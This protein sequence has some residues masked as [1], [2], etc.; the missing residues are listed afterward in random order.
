MRIANRFAAGAAVIASIVLCSAMAYAE[1]KIG[2]LIYSGEAHYVEAARGA[3]DK[4]KEEG[5]GEP[6]ATFIVENAGANKAKA[7]DLAQKLAAAKLDLII[8]LGTSATIAAMREIRDVP[9]V[10]ALV[11]DPVEAGIAKTWESSGNNTTG[12]SSKIPMSRLMETLTHFEQVKR[13]AVLYTPGEKN[14]ELSLKDLQAVQDKYRIKI[15]PVGMTRPEEFGQLLP[16]VMSTVDAVY[17]TGSSL[18]N[19]RVSEIADMAVKAKVITITHLDDLMYKGLLVGV[20]ADAYLMGQSAGA[21]A[22]KILKGAKPASLPIESPK[23]VD[24]I[25]NTRT[26]NKGQFRIPPNLMTTVTKRIE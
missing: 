14:S 16:E 11:Y 15:L 21:K 17:V 25:L 6:K 12:S 3:R 26:V 20:G 4:L 10:F 5:F 23:K 13:L 7:A 1:K 22:A 2:V 24:V 9:I 8:T 19:S 18:V